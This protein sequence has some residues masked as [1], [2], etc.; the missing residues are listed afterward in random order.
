MAAANQ[1]NRMGY[2]VT[3]FEKDEYVGG[4]LRFGI[5]N[6]KLNKAIIDR[7]VD[8]MAAEGITF[9]TWNTCLK[10]SMP[11]ASVP[12]HRRHATSTS[13]DATSKAYTSHWKCSP[14][15]TAS[16]PDRHSARKN[17]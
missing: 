3:V 11:T 8:I 4:L 2:E 12:G 10:V 15:K 16:W 6:F 14:N 7:R 17:A 9:K 13:R 1:L 5:P